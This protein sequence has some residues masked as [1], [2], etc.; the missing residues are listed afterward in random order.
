MESKPTVRGLQAIIRRLV[1]LV[2]GLR[3]VRAVGFDEAVLRD[4]LARE[5]LELAGADADADAEIFWKPG[6]SSESL[7]NA[8]AVA[9]I[10]AA[11]TTRPLP[12]PAT[13][14]PAQTYIPLRDWVG[15]WFSP[16]SFAARTL[17]PMLVSPAVGDRPARVVLAGSRECIFTRELVA[18]PARERGAFVKMALV[19]GFGCGFFPLMPA[20][21]A[22]A[23]M[24]PVALA[25][26]LLA[27]WSVF[28]AIS[29]ATFVLS[30]AASVALEKWAGRQMLAEDPREFVL[31]E[32]AGMAVTWM[33]LPPGAPWWAVIIGFFLF[34]IFDIF[35]WGVDWVEKLPI[36]GKIVWDDVLAGLYA[37]AVL[38]GICR[39]L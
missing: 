9:V 12:H 16:G 11:V 32:F 20:T 7:S 31:D 39:F 37:G 3:T 28:F 36:A 8:L 21:L 24:V 22:C 18:Q 35:K 15:R 17:A 1:F 13:D 19:S 34:R 38:W 33:F 5:N 10:A 6:Q 26:Y 29:G 30:T 23:V 25:L 14:R 4:A 2:P 27:G